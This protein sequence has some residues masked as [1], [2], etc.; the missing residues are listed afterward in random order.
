[1]TKK[2]LWGEMPDIA[3]IRTPHEILMEQG[4]YLSEMTQG[5]LD[6]AIE[7][8]QKNTLFSY[9]FYI[10]VPAIDYRLALLR[11]THDIKL[12]PAILASENTGE[13]YT[14]NNQDEFEED[15]GS[16]LSSEETKVAISGLLAQARLEKEFKE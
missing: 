11:V 7:R 8:K 1:M 12:Y 15:L 13:E 16:V 4:Q 3:S 6:Y 9:D 14:A 10:T 2:S 5:L